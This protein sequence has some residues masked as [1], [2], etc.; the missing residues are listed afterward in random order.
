MCAQKCISRVK[1]H[2]FVAKPIK[3]L[4]IKVLLVVRNKDFRYNGYM[5]ELPITQHI[6]ELADKHCR[7][8]GGNRVLKVNLVIGDYSGYVGESVQMY[9]DVI[10]QGTLCEGAKCEIEHVEPKSRC[11]KCGKLFKRELL[12]FQCPYCGGDSEPT[13]IGKEFYI[14][15]IEIE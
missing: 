6:I 15:S 9:F 12:S 5:H 13:D 8:N 3:P 11:L 14:D 7:D 2:V 4:N 1:V 10:S